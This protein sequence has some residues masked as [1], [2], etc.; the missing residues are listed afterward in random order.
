MIRNHAERYGGDCILVKNNQFASFKDGKGVLIGLRQQCAVRNLF[1][2]REVVDV[3][4]DIYGLHVHVVSRYWN[5][6]KLKNYMMLTSNVC[7][8]DN[9]VE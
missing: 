8:D 7:A 6:R 1:R 4:V 5:P 3:R 2:D 9:G